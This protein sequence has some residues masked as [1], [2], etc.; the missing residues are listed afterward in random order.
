MIDLYTGTPGSGKSLHA[1]RC[2]INRLKSGGGLIC[3]FP[4]N[5]AVVK[6]PKAHVEYWDNSEL[7]A[8]RLVRYAMDHHKIGLEGQTLVVVDEC[9]LIFS[10]R[11]FGR[12]DRNAWITLF[13]QHRK[14][15]YNFILITQSERMLD[16]QIRSMIETETRHRKLNNYGLG[17][18]LLCLFLGNTSWFMAIEYWSGGNKL[19][20]SSTM[21]CYRKKYGQA[22]DS[23][24]LFSDLVT[25]G[26]A[27]CAGGHRVSGGAP[28]NGGTAPEYPA[29]RKALVC[30]LI[31]VLN[32][33][34][35]QA[36]APAAARGTV[37]HRLFR[38]CI[39]KV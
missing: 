21:F 1:A 2:I 30:Q 9:Q 15:G 31:G 10:C 33:M 26:G 39:A 6:K 20:L 32:V 12:K 3:N 7:S 37:I 22:Y 27:V 13:S 16:K 28:G 38:R 5:E 18:W 36:P 29:E 11:D 8:D 23:Y 4:V 17:G 24:R 35:N 34:Q 19:K 25:A 14:L